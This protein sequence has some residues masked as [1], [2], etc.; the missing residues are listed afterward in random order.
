MNEAQ[1][2]AIADALGGE[3]W[4]SGGDIWIVLMRRDDGKV[5]VISGDAVCLYADSEAF[6]RGDAEHAIE[7]A[8]SAKASLG[9]A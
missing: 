6:D 9:H 3:T 7:F 8:A 2:T 4:Q 1:A 5:V